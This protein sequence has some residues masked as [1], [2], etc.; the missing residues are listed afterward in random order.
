MADDI[1][2]APTA[3]EDERRLHELGYAQELHAAHVRVLELRRLVHD[4]LDPVRLPDPVRVR[5]EHRRPRDHRLGLA[6][7]RADDAVR[8]PGHGRGLLQLPDRRRPV[9]LVGQAGA[10]R[11]APAWS[12]FTGWFNFLGQVAVTAGIDFGA[13]FF[14]NAFLDLQFGL[15]A[16]RTGHTILIFGRSC[17]SCT[18]L[19]NQ[20]G[21]RLVALLNDISVWW[22]VVGV[23]DHRRPCW[24]SCRPPPVGQLRVRPLRQQHRL[25]QHVLRRCCSACCW[26]S[27]RSPGTTPRRT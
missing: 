18:A 19:L 7:R 25:A 1:A 27:T 10:A 11:T 14:I 17:C 24:P 6:D 13:A 3:G 20:F 23:A 26:R 15:R 16:P 8:R 9:L 4:H 21:V 5:H 2:A 22:H 12:W